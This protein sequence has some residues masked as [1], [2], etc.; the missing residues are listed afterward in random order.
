MVRSK[1]LPRE[2]L[3]SCD[4]ENFPSANVFLWTHEGYL[5]TLTLLL[6]YMS[7]L[8]SVGSWSLLGIPV[9]RSAL[10]PVSIPAVRDRELQCSKVV[11]LTETYFCSDLLVDRLYGKKFP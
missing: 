10:F 3:P 9:E 2:S 8:R 1:E 4:C 11:M 7:C 5:S 6:I